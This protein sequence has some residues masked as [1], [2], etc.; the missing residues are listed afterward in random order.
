MVAAVAALVG[1][2]IAVVA[3]VVG[4]VLT[5]SSNSNSNNQLLKTDM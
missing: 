3:I 4:L 1:F 2:D 5:P